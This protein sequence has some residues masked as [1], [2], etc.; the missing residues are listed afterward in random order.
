MSR[1]WLG[2]FADRPV[3]GLQWHYDTFTLPPGAQAILFGRHCQNQGFVMRGMH[4]AVQSHFEMTPDL[5]RR[6]SCNWS[7]R[8][9]RE[10][11]RFGG[12]ATQP[13]AEITADLQART[14]AVN[15]ILERLYERWVT[16]L[17]RD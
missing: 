2:E 9:A 3:P 11:A 8:I 10:I 14:D 13:A 1:E 5:L 12:V 15:R 7:G 4:L 16:G 6:W 17:K